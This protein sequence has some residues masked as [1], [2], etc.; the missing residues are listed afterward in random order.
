MKRYGTA[1]LL[2]CVLTMLVVGVVEAHANLARSTP[3]AGDVLA[4][5][6]AEIVMEFTENL[7]P[8]F[9]KAQLINCQNQ[10]VNP[11][12]GQID[13]AKPKVWHLT[14]GALPKDSYTVIWRARSATDGHITNGNIPFGIGV[15]P[16]PSEMAETLLKMM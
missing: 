6:P 1:I 13:P 5:A 3:A 15:A 12:P 4:T 16:T 8:S 2:V 7:D 9:T 10:V 14:I 11:G